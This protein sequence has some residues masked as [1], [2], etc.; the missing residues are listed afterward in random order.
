MQSDFVPIKVEVGMG[1]DRKRWGKCEVKWIKTWYVYESTSRDKTL[2]MYHK[3]TLIERRNSKNKL[4][5]LKKCLLRI[6][7][8]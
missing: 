3:H 4:K 7:L 1:K 5:L 2:T 6:L 8:F